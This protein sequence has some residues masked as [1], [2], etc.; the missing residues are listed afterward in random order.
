MKLRGLMLLGIAILFSNTLSAQRTAERDLAM[1]HY[2]VGLENLRSE[3]WD[4]A[5]EAFQKAID[6][7]STFDM[8]YY[9]LGKANMSR[10][11]YAEAA[12]ALVKCRDLY[13]AQA[14][15]QFANQQEAQR[16]RRDRVL[17]I[18]EVIRQYRS[19]P[20]NL[21]TAESIRQL[22]DRKRQMMSN[23]ERGT[24][25]TID[26][27]VPAYVSLALGSADFRMGKLTDAEHAYKAAIEADPRTGEAHSNLAV[28]YLQTDRIDEAEK[29]IKAAEKTGF[30]VNPMLKDDIAAK[31]KK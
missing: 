18:D 10:K 15:R 25:V 17:E 19:G 21:Q 14:G 11:R 6:A 20:Q 1:P 29:A 26:A 28:V 8:A 4:K 12:A 9:A 31:K 3:A 24:N 16:Y 30:K 27:T 23:I 7:D 2:K 5:A 13:L 22:E